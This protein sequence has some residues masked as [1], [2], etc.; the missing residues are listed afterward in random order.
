[1]GRGAIV[2]IYRQST[3]TV[4]TCAARTSRARLCALPAK[5]RRAAMDSVAGQTSTRARAAA[6]VHTTSSPAKSQTAQRARVRIWVRAFSHC[7][8]NVTAVR[9]SWNRRD[10]ATRRYAHGVCASSRC[11]TKCSS[12]YFDRAGTGPS[13]G[14][15]QATDADGG[16]VRE[17]A[18]STY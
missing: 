15:V 12:A 3:R 1:M 18:Y 5:S 11:S 6:S 10:L 8:S 9:R 17:T 7:C 16:R 2:G 4:G 14:P 13:R